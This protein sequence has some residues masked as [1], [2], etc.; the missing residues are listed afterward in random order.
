M[1]YLKRRK[2]ISQERNTLAIVMMIATLLMC[3]Y[4]RFPVFAAEP[5]ILYADNG[6]HQR[7]NIGPVETEPAAEETETEEVTPKHEYSNIQISE[8]EY[9]ELCQIVAAEAQT[10]RLEG[11]KAVV[12]VIFNRVISDR[13]PNTV[14]GVLSQKGQFSTWKM[15]NYKWVQPELVK[16]AVDSVIKDGRQVLPDTQYMYFS[17]GRSKYGKNWFKLQDH[18]FGQIR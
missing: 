3:Y 17:R 8:S 12:E 14:H 13:W 15:R 16:E 6:A 4:M 1:D 5:T 2:R 9:I 11:Q 7:K 18:W 10:Q